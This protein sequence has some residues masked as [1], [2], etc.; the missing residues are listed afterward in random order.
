MKCL[1]V[2]SEAQP[3]AASGGLADVA[4]SLPK[5]VAENGSIDIRV[6]MPL[7]ASIKNEY[8]EKFEYLGNFT[9]HLSWRQEYCGLFRYY[10]DGVTYYFIDNERYFKRD[11]LY[12]YYDDG[13]RFAY[14][15]KA[16]VEALPHLNFF[17]DIIHCNDWQSALVSA[18]I[19]TGNWSD[20]RYYKI[21]HIY[22]IHNIEYQGVYGMENLKDL[23]G[24]DPRFTRDMEYNGDINLSKAAILYSD[25]FTTVSD[26]YCDNLKQPY[27]SRGLHHTVI[28]HE[29][30]LRGIVNG[31]DPDFYNP[32]TDKCLYKNYSVETMEEKVM[33]KKLWQDELGLPVD[34]RT[35]M[36]SV[37]S[38]LVS[39]KGIDLLNKIIEQVLQQDVQFIIVGT[40]D[41][42]Y[43]NYYKYLEN[44]YPT[45][46]R[47][48]V[49]KYSNEN[50]RRAYG[51]SDIFVM[52]SKVEPCGI[53]QMIASRYGA[54]P[55][56]REV[57]GL[58][59]TIKDF[60]CVGG[61]N[62]YTFTNYNPNDLLYQLNRA[63]N[64]YK[65]IDGWKRKMQ[66]CM[67]K[68][69]SWKVSAKKYIDLYKSLV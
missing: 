21:K 64:D 56:V 18:Y 51:A 44:K 6:I 69:F 35:P 11:K 12:G 19:K 58:K 4:G 1:F 7:Y 5:A 32:A 66:I 45:K 24:I 33:N 30:K 40:G 2:T 42:K 10:S 54:I 49:D 25:L 14:F 55:I 17:P 46:V 60:G 36:I 67:T 13:E 47:A 28:R 52:P 15:S 38:R 37:V 53:S 63:I 16:I 31:I 26:S 22:T 48:L 27:T 23:F 65:D 20:F 34:S 62:G 68:D 39:H 57:G 61:G 43:V 9:V 3:F 41:E 8:R 29:Y 50:A 59:D